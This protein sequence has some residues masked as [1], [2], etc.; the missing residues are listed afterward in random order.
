ME[1]TLDQAARLTGVSVRRV[2]AAVASGDLPLHRV[3]GRSQTVESTILRAW[4]RSLSTGRRWNDRVRRAAVSLFDSDN[5]TVELSY[6]EKSRLRRSLRELDSAGMAHRLGASSGWYRYRAVLADRKLLDREVT[7]TGL[8][9]LTPEQLAGMGLA[10][11]N[12]RIFYGIADD[13]NEAESALGLVLDDEGDVLLT[14]NHRCGTGDLAALANAYLFGSTRESAA[15]AS[16]L[17]R[18]LVAC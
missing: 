11:G 13:L 4:Q 7:P 18:R 10:A 3:V 2:Q 16:A 12:S 5:V 14:D 17:E 8:S 1:L 15:A 9:A 6:S